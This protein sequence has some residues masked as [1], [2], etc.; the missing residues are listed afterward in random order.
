MVRPASAPL[1]EAPAPSSS[2]LA[3]A[4]AVAAMATFCFL[5]GLAFKSEATSG[6]RVRPAYT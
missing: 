4:A 5:V 6:A 1:D 2:V 3:A